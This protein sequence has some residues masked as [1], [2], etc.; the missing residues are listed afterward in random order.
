MVSWGDINQIECMR[1][2]SQRGPNNVINSWCCE[3]ETC[4]EL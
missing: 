3:S 1:A 2:C 4:I